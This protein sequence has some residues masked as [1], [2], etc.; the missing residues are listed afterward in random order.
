MAEAERI[1]ILG[2]LA[3]QG[4]TEFLRRIIIVFNAPH[5]SLLGAIKY[6]DA[7]SAANATPEMKKA[8]AVLENFATMGPWQRES[9]LVAFVP[10]S[11][12]LEVTIEHLSAAW[13][14]PSELFEEVPHRPIIT[15]KKSE[16]VE[17]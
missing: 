6:F 5:Q 12:K 11:A 3:V 9:E 15:D 2:A 16:G 10:M 8:R 13:A 7:Y 1:K 17:S 4:K 14:V